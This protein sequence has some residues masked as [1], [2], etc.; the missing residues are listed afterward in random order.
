MTGKPLRR[1]NANITPIGNEIVT[2]KKVNNNVK[3][4]PPH[5]ADGTEGNRITG[6]ILEAPGIPDSR[7]QLTGNKA[8]HPITVNRLTVFKL[9]G[10]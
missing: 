9:A 4:R 2:L 3:T 5:S 1:P 10:V 8:T 6:D 7:Y